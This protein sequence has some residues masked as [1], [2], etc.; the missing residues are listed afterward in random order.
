MLSIF[1]LAEFSASTLANC[2]FRASRNSFQVFQVSGLLPSAYGVIHSAAVSLSTDFVYAILSASNVTVV[3]PK[4]LLHCTSHARSW[5]RS[6]PNPGGGLTFGRWWSLVS[7]STHR[8]CT[9]CT[10]MNP[11]IC[12]GASGRSCAGGRFPVELASP[13]FVG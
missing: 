13:G 10:S 4:Y 9:S 2:P 3:A 1:V 5:L 7:L 12:T 6:P 11:A 8:N